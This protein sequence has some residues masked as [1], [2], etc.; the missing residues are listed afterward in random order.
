MK[1]IVI[2]FF[3]VGVIISLGIVSSKY[4]NND[5]NLISDKTLISYYVETGYKSGEYQEQE[6]TTWPEGYV[7]NKEKSFCNG[8]SILEWDD[9][10]NAV[11]VT[12]KRSDKCKI[13]LDKQQTGA[14]YIESLLASNPETMNNDDPDGNV[15]YMGA[16]PNN[17]VTFNNE[18]WRIIGVFDVKSSEDGQPE[19][20][21]KLIRDESIGQYSWDA[22]VSSINNGWGI[23]EWSQ[24]D[25]MH[26][27]NSGPYWNRTNGACYNGEN[28]SMVNCDFSSNG[29]RS[30]SKKYIESAVWNTGTMKE[31][32]LDFNAESFYDYER[33]NNAG[34]ICTN[35]ENCTDIVVRTTTWI[36]KVGLLYSSD[37]SYATSGGTVN[38][39]DVCLQT[40]LNVWNNSQHSDC[41][42]E[43]WLYNNEE[44]LFTITPFPMS[45]FNGAVLII[46]S[47]GA[48]T[49]RNA[50]YPSSIYPVVYLKSTVK[51][52]GGDG[53][54]TSPYQ[55][56]A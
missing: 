53:I 28:N 44:S 10:N 41:R 33:S 56:S 21:I 48:I 37:Y 54:S 18:L 13:Y 2:S 1:K 42:N 26:L 25:L 50:N 12:A 35:G 47:S 30:E 4:F 11:I 16:N 23:N 5:E 17:Y 7:L 15:R 45:T 49:T 14:E 27:L 8:E 38:T 39:R 24:A 52:S 46:F 31:Q 36:G 29:L 9:K 3:I 55:L 43:N 40:F 51:I 20:R 34:K 22:S 32:S 6:G 19:K